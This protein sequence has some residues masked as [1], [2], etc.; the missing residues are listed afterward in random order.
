MEKDDGGFAFPVPHVIDG[1]W[2]ISPHK[3]YSGMSLRDYFAAASLQGIMDWDAIVNN[4]KDKRMPIFV[5]SGAE[6]RIAGIA[7]KIADAMLAERNKP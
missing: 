4:R 7:Y 1:N 3:E 6:K 2:V 5:E